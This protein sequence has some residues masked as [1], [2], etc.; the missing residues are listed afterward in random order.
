[1]SDPKRLL[2]VMGAIRALKDGR[3]PVAREL[4]GVGKFAIV[5]L[6]ER[7]WKEVPEPAKLAMLKDL[8]DWSGVTNKDQAHILLSELNVGALTVD[9]RDQ[10]IRQ[11]V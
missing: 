6:D 4:A 3:Y 10:L 8:V 5:K 7:P 9:Q 11:G 1:M 2:H